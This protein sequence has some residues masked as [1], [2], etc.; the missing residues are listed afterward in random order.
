MNADLNKIDLVI[1]YALLT[2]GEEDD[3]YSRQLG[4]IHLIKYVYLAD[5]Y[6]AKKNN[7]QTYTG[8]DW[9]F[10]N[11]GPWSKLVHSRI[12]PALTAVCANKATFESDYGD[13][14]WSRWN[15]RNEYLLTDKSK[16]LPSTITLHLRKDI[17]KFLKDTPSLLDFAYKTAPMLNAAPG[18]QLD[19]SRVASSK[20]QEVEEAPKLRM[21]SLSS[22]KQKLFSDK[23]KQLRQ[24]FQE[25][26][27][28][29][30]ELVSPVKEPA[31]DEVYRQ[32]V[33]WLDSLAGESFSVKKLTAEFSDEVWKSSTRNSD[34]IP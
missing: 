17:H 6:Y 2:A 28:R 11:F 4:P 22:K 24:K 23:M 25:S 9:Q 20:H 7:G 32:G 19:F 18:E 21:S 33:Q 27:T 13:S 34:D 26:K 5:L 16:Q 10:Y 14:D 29:K 30:P 12:E 31:F 3:L 8:V 15:L 1:Q